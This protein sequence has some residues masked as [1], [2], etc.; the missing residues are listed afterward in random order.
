MLSRNKKA[1]NAIN[2][3]D[4]F[5]FKVDDVD[6]GAADPPNIV[7]VILEKNESMFKLGHKGG[8]LKEWFPFN[9]LQ[10]LDGV[11][12]SFT[13]NDVQ[14]DKLISVREA[15]KFGS[16]AGGQGFKACNCK[17]GTCGKGTR[18]SCFKNGIKCNS[19]CHNGND[20]KNC[21][22]KNDRAK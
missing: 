17:T 6:R 14:M 22:M 12:M 1:I 13:R 4:I 8:V 10:K 9:V 19:R 21:T 20:N 11:A 16:V 3:D 7:S 18:C 5:L 2:V 15:V